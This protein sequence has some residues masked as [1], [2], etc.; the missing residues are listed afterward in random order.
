MP[1]ARAAAARLYEKPEEKLHIASAERWRQNSDCGQIVG[2]AMHGMIG[3]AATFTKAR[4]RPI[5]GRARSTDLSRRRI[6]VVEDEAAIA[7][8]LARLLRD[9]G[10]TV[11]GPVPSADEALGHIVRTHLHCA[12]LDVKLS[13]GDCGTVAQALTWNAVP[14]AFI[15]GYSNSDVVARY[16][17]SP[18]LAKPYTTIDVIDCIETLLA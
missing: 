2:W 16:S 14:F 13:H 1:E 11:F 15:T 4:N 5:G 10:A 6:L 3:N 17:W 12:L 9:Y 7:L 8:D 18:V